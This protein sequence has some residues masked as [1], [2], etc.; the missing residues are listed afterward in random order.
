MTGSLL[1]LESKSCPSRLTLLLA[2]LMWFLLPSSLLQCHLVYIATL[3]P[4]SL[5]LVFSY[6]LFALF[7]LSIPCLLSL[8]FVP[9]QN[10]K[11]ASVADLEG[12][13]ARCLQIEHISPLMLHLQRSWGLPISGARGAEAPGGL[14]GDCAWVR[15]SPWRAG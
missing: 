15:W 2:A 13:K 9:V 1:S 5:N 10:R 14:T 8:Y 11:Y 3:E 4:V 6:C 7:G 12:V